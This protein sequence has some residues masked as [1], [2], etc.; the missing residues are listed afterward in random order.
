MHNL[1]IGGIDFPEKHTLDQHRPNGF[2]TPEVIIDEDTT[3]TA[4][5]ETTPGMCFQI[6]SV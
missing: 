4:Y 2:K 1:R 6:D 5:V 3:T